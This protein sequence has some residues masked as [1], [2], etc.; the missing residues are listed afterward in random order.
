MLAFILGVA[1]GV[2]I[3]IEKN[4][5]EKELKK[6]GKK[7]ENKHVGLKAGIIGVSIW[8]QFCK[9]AKKRK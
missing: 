3:L 5:E 2:I 1:I 4:E 6:Q 8:N 7:K 9:D